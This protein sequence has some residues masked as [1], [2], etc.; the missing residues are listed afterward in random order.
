MDE[1]IRVRT[2]HRRAARSAD[3]SRSYPR[4]ERRVLSPETLQGPATA[5]ARS[6]AG[7]RRQPQYRRNPRPLIITEPV[8]RN[9]PHEGPLRIN[10]QRWRWP[11]FTP[12]QWPA[13]APPLTLG[14]KPAPPVRRLRV[15][16]IGDARIGL[17]ALQG[18]GRRRHPP[19]RHRQFAHAVRGSADDRGGIVG[20]GPVANLRR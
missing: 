13:F 2:A 9:G 7:R 18:K 19:P 3:S 4:D 1:C 11:T 20:E 10:Q 16:D 5:P 17:L 15:P 12:P 14:A 6:R 8:M